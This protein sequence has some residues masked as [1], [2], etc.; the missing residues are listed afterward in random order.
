MYALAYGV[1][2]IRSSG[3]SSVRVN[4]SVTVVA[5][6]VDTVVRATTLDVVAA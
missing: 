5:R 2:R 4:D 6:S 1:I 3:R